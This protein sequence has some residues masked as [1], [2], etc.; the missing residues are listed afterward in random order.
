MLDLL[1]YKS[2]C[3]GYLIWSYYIRKEN[4]LFRAGWKT[5]LAIIIMFFYEN[6]FIYISFHVFTFLELILNGLVLNFRVK[7]R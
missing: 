4:G 3:E 6:G 5:T 2:T 7:E 1:K